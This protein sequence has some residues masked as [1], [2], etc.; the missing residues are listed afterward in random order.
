MK[1]TQEHW[2]SKIDKYCGVYKS[3]TTSWHQNVACYPG[4]AT[5][6]SSVLDLMAIYLHIHSYNHSYYKFTNS[7]L[8]VLDLFCPASSSLS[9]I[10]LSDPSLSVSS[11][12]HPLKRI[13]W[14]LEREHLLEG[15]SLSIH[16]NTSV[17]WQRLTVGCLCMRCR[18]K[19]FNCHPDEDTRNLATEPLSSNGRPLRLRY[20]GFQ[21]HDTILHKNTLSALHTTPPGLQIQNCSQYVCFRTCKR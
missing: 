10:S 21:R 12:S 2:Y 15:L 14:R 7:L 18:V 6:N 9:L 11:V 20:S 3:I 13:L 5:N 4:N 16:E 8:S 17:D 19:V 1:N